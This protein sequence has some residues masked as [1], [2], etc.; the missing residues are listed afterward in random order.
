MA[1]LQVILVEHVSQMVNGQRVIQH[2]HVSHQSLFGMQFLHH[3]KVA[4]WSAIPEL[5]LLATSKLVLGD[6]AHTMDSIDT[7]WVLICIRETN[8]SP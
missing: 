5:Q 7:F 6:P 4:L 3:R 1:G 2:V 8:V